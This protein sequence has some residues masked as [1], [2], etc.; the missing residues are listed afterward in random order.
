VILLLLVEAEARARADEAPADPY[1]T[2]VTAVSPLHGSGLP[3]E[4]VPAHVQTATDADLRATQSLDVAEFMAGALGGVTAGEAQ[5]NPLQPD[6]QFRGF[7]ASPLLGVAQGLAVYVDGARLN[8]PFGDVVNWDLIPES[9]IASIELI[10]GSNPLFGLNAL[11]GALS[12]ETKT[13]FSHPGSTARLLGGSF[14]RRAATFELGA[15]GERFG[16]FVT[17]HAVAEDGW[18]A[19]SPSD[20][21]QLFAD[22]TW[23]DAVG[24]LDLSLSAVD[25]ALHGNG[26]APVDLLEQERSAV[27]T[28]PDITTD[29][30]LL[31]NLRGERAL[32]PWLRLQGNLALRAQQNQGRNGDAASYQRCVDPAQQDQLCRPVRDG[33]TPVLDAAGQ[34]VA[35][36]ERNPFDASINAT[37]TR[38]NGVGGTLQAQIAAPVRGRENHLLLGARGDAASAAFRSQVEVGRLAADR[39]TLPTGITDLGAAVGVDASTLVVGVFASDTLSITRALSVTASALFGVN[40]VSLTDRL[41]DALTGRHSF[42][43]VSPAG[44]VTYQPRPWLGVYA[45]AGESARAPSPVELTC[46]RPDAPCRLPNAFVADPPLDLVVARTY[47]AGARG[48]VRVSDRLRLSWDAGAFRTDIDRDILFVSAGKLRSEGYFENVGRTRRHG[49]ELDV[50]GRLRTG[51]PLGR[52]AHWFAF[53]HATVLE[54]TFETPFRA[55]GPNHPLAEEGS[56][57]VAAG[58]RIPGVPSATLKAGLGVMLADALSVGARLVA[59]SGQYLRGDEANLLPQLPGWQRVDITAEL[60]LGRA[61]SL[62]ARVTNLLGAQYSTFGVLGDAGDVIKEADDPRFLA[63][64]AP[65][66]GWL[67]LELRL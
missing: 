35:F 16:A 55:P 38:Q 11:G 65:R 36:D 42:V 17:G 18:R 28:Y 58:A 57:A 27:F 13:G 60:Q 34:P 63:P 62:F 31:V 39:Q 8:E 48:R 43:R 44:G 19:H 54:A 24:S 45:G 66:A 56:I 49:L 67:G 40:Q 22:A 32:R 15:H 41:G 51:G 3:R 10:P 37:R 33:Q 20:V 2:V 23:R 6:L 46:A 4:R 26:T 21:K 14:A 12:L 61:V 64:A 53:A 1:E 52:P 29:R 50:D 5:G 9:A 59:Q 7:S 25:S 30:V 47:E